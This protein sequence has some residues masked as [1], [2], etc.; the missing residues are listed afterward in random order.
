VRFNKENVL[1]TVRWEG[2]LVIKAGSEEDK[3]LEGHWDSSTS[4][5]VGMFADLGFFGRAV[6]G[7]RRL[8]WGLSG[9]VRYTILGVSTSADDVIAWAREQ[10]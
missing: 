2:E 4:T 3:V 1:D 7:N 8:E 6:V 5:P 10:S 9:R